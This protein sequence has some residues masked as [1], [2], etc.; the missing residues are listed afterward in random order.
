MDGAGR[1]RI[2][3]EDPSKDGSLGSGSH[4]GSLHLHPPISTCTQTHKAHHKAQV[5]VPAGVEEFVGAAEPERKEQSVGAAGLCWSLTHCCSCSL[6]GLGFPHLLLEYGVPPKAFQ[7][8]SSKE[9]LL[10]VQ[11][12]GSE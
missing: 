5:P 3:G 12:S 6:G 10:S 11:L 2:L 8:R 9:V 1:G 7:R 4:L